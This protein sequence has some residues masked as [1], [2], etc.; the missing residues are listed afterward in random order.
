MDIVSS[1]Q[2]VLYVALA[3][4]VL[5]FTVFL[6]WLLFEAARIL[7]NANRIVESLTHKLELINEAVQY[8]RG[9]VDGVSKNMGVMSSM[10][11]GLV[12]KFIVGKL[13]SKL[14]KKVKNTI[15]RKKNSS[16][17]KTTQKKSTSKRK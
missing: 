9:K 1:S 3:L 6:C 2:D 12:E 13:A 15:S 8:M 11:T 16:A 10:M 17:K 14:E 7:K 4:C 5:F